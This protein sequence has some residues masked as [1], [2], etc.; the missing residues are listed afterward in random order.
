M[1]VAQIVALSMTFVQLLRRKASG[2]RCSGID[3]LP[4]RLCMFAW[5]I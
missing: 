1:F 2:G 3:C 4:V 5:L